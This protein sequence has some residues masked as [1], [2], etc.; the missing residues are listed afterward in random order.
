MKELD[1]RTNEVM[2]RNAKNIAG[3]SVDIARLSG[4]T[5]IKIETI[6]ECLHLTSLGGPKRLEGLGAGAENDFTG[7]PSSACRG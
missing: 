7:R 4:T 6:E 2:I 1:R 3:Q 5:G